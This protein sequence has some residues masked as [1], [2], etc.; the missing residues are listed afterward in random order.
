M[1]KPVCINVEIWHTHDFIRG[2]GRITVGPLYYITYV[3]SF[4]RAGTY[5]K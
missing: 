2:K 1:Q 5:T 3:F 4:G